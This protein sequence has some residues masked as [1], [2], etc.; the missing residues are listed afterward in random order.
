MQPRPRLAF[1]LLLV[2][3][4]RT[5][6]GDALHEE[7]GHLAHEEP[8]HRLVAIVREINLR[9]DIDAGAPRRVEPIAY[10]V[11]PLRSAFDVGWKH[12]G[13]AVQ[14]QKS[15]AALGRPAPLPERDVPLGKNPHDPAFL[16]PAQGPA[17]A[18]PETIV[19]RRR[20]LALLT[21]A[22]VVVTAITV[23]IATS[24]G[25][26]SKGSP[27]PVGTTP[28][29]AT[30]APTTPPGTTTTSATRQPTTPQTQP[31]RTSTSLK[32]TLPAGGTLSIGDSGPSVVTL[33]KVLA[34]LKLKVGSP[35]GKFGS[36]TQAT[37]IAFQTAHA[38]SPDGIVG[39]ATAQKLN[40]ALASAGARD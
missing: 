2:P 27:A 29:S 8:I 9:P 26:S 23:A 33:Q 11:S 18:G 16:Q 14:G 35:D 10:Q 22:L 39:A 21:L 12:G 40:E 5:Q 37:V 34:A 30:E 36:R 6:G 20:I 31:T 13:A 38:L 32:M 17:Q 1:C 19:R 28:Q 24:G 25:G 7:I 15:S 4:A 3:A